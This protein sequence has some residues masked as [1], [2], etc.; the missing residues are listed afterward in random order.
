MRLREGKLV[1]EWLDEYENRALIEEVEIK[2]HRGSTSEKAY[3]LS[4]YAEYD[5]DF[6]Y[7]VS[8]FDS[9]ES[10]KNQLKEFSC[11]S[12][13]NELITRAKNIIRCLESEYRNFVDM[14]KNDIE[15]IKTTKAI[16]DK[17]KTELI[18]VIERVGKAYIDNLVD[19][20]IIDYDEAKIL[21]AYLKKIIYI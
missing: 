5:N 20:F 14:S 11:G 8:I 1:S 4:C 3:R 19:R 13:K 18:G 2:P 17:E 15:K 12:F 7:Y 9:V 21:Y 10:A 16:D 6:C